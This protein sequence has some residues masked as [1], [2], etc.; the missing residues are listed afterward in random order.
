[1][2]QNCPN[3]YQKLFD[4]P[5]KE[6]EKWNA[7]AL[8]V[9]PIHMKGREYFLETE[10]TLK[11]F[12]TVRFVNESTTSVFPH[13]KQCGKL[14]QVKGYVSSIGTKKYVEQHK[15]FICTTCKEVI[16]CHAYYNKYHSF[17]PPTCCPG[18]YG[19]LIVRP[20]VPFKKYVRY[21]QEMIISGE[22]DNSRKQK[23]LKVTVEDDLVDTVE[24]GDGIY[25][26]GTL[27][28]RQK[29]L[30]EGQETN[31]EMVIKANSVTQIEKKICVL[32][33]EDKFVV[34]D[35]WCN[36]LEEKG[37]FG[38]RDHLLASFDPALYAMTI[39]KFLVLISLAS[40]VENE[41]KRPHSHVLFV[42]APGI[43][44]SHLLQRASKL[45][46]KSLFAACK[47]DFL[48]RNNHFR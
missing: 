34:E 24:L 37:E 33:P 38:A 47:Y 16:L 44:K 4:Q 3:L 46:P 40:C 14:F 8:V 6:F 28:N 48:Y 43:S 13:Y 32:T 42:G 5:K 15:E 26:V 31:T 17:Q 39:P 2:K 27:E 21:I 29:F 9:L 19:N 36:L 10:A 35:D 45:S 1:M 23:L 41:P 7:A 18:C 11:Q 12:V 22:S 20:D 30:Y 25:V